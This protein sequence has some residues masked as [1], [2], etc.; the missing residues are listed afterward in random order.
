MDR[1]K[2][3]RQNKRN[4]RQEKNDHER[5]DKED[6]RVNVP[7]EDVTELT[8]K[9]LKNLTPKGEEGKSKGKEEEKKPSSPYMMNK[10]PFWQRKP[11]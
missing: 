5:T 1:K 3:E 4:G 8:F 6:V 11:K 10:N 7:Y 2:N 9:Q